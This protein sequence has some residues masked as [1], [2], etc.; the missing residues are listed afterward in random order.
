MTLLHECILPSKDGASPAPSPLPGM[1]YVTSK[2]W[3]FN[4]S[5]W[6][7]SLQDFPQ[8]RMFY[9]FLKPLYVLEGR[10]SDKRRVLFPAVMTGPGPGTVLVSAL[11]SLTLTI[12]LSL[13]SPDE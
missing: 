8:N 9:S 4:L 3:F 6:H 5:F 2:V 13:F 10:D 12:I 11:S 1:P 7:Y